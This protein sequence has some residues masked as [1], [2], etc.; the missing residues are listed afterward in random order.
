MVLGWRVV[1]GRRVM[2][3]MNILFIL[4][5]TL[6]GKKGGDEGTERNEVT[7]EWKWSRE[8][9]EWRKVRERRDDGK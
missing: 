5:I 3:S 2:W 7:R 4:H 6:Y 9:R 8:T 1:S